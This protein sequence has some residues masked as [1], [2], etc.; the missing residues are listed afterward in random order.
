VKG[1]I[2][3]RLVL[4]LAAMLVL[5]VAGVFAAVALA[6]GNTPGGT[7]GSATDDFT[8]DGQTISHN[9]YGPPWANGAD[10]GRGWIKTPLSFDCRA[11]TLAMTE[12]V[13]YTGDEVTENFAPPPGTVIVGLL[14]ATQTE[15]NWTSASWADDGSSASVTMAGSGK[16]R[17]W[18]DSRIFYCV[19]REGSTSTET[20]TV[21]TPGSTV[22]VTT[23]GSTTTF[24]PPPQHHKKHHH[25][26]TFTPPN[27]KLPH[28]S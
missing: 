28:T 10:R 5:A 21:T 8:Y 6:G 24:T 14:W 20:T 1:V 16:D 3:K 4:P 26:Q 22:T 27:V 11:G 2:E 19:P 17:V 12:R 15:T 13:R 23:P 25:R 7:S 18:S 9:G